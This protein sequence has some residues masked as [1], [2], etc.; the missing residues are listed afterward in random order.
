MPRSPTTTRN[1]AENILA[2]REPCAEGVG[3]MAVVYTTDEERDPPLINTKVSNHKPHTRVRTQIEFNSVGIER[4]LKSQIMPANRGISLHQLPRTTD[5]AFEKEQ[6]N[7]A[8]LGIFGHIREERRRYSSRPSRKL[9]IHHSNGR[10]VPG[11]NDRTLNSG[12]CDFGGANKGMCYLTAT[13]TIDSKAVRG[14]L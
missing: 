8:S 9:L 10:H 3:A 2:R 14:I 12:S 6:D 13:S 5:E 1:K 7:P 11:I 4:S